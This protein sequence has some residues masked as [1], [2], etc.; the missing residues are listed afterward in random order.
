MQ[1]TTVRI[2]ARGCRYVSRLFLAL[3]LMSSTVVLGQQA[4]SPKWQ[5]GVAVRRITPEKLLW[6]A[7]YGH[8]DHP[9]EGTL[10]EL[11]AKAI[12]LEDAESQ[13]ILLITLDLVGIDK[14]LSDRIRDEIAETLQF[15]RAHV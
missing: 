1:N 9:A 7:G 6:M 14:A 11:Y 3:V 13:R 2:C 10:T 8:R 12:C 15:D 5:A 4:D